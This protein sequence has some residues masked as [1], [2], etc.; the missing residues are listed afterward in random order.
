MSI[1]THIASHG[2]YV[3]DVFDLPTLRAS[4]SF[5]VGGD[6]STRYVGQTRANEPEINNVLKLQGQDS[7]GLHYVMS[8]FRVGNFPG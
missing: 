1:G 5:S 2:K 4:R 8:E 7:T 6:G 3:L